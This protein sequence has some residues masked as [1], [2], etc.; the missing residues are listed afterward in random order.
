[1]NSDENNVNRSTE[2]TYI[3]ADGKDVTDTYTAD[4]TQYSNV[5]QTG[6]QEKIANMALGFGIGS[7][8]IVFFAIPSLIYGYKYKKQSVTTESGLKKSK[9]GII[10]SYIAIGIVLLAQLTKLFG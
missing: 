1:M 8:F 6:T 2:N 7:L 3:E 10:I 5:P 4:P 9:A